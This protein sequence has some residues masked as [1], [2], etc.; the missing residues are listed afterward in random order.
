MGFAQP[1]DWSTRT[2][3]RFDLTRTT[4]TSVMVAIKLGAEWSWCQHTGAWQP[5]PTTVEVDLASLACA[6]DRSKVHELYIWF[7]RGEHNIDNVRV[8]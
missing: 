6:Q 1:Q 2:R 7:S 4:G 8:S 3:L 5:S